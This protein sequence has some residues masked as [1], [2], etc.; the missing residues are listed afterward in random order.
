MWLY[1][2][3]FGPAAVYENI[4]T[5]DFQ[6]YTQCWYWIAFSSF[7]MQILR[8]FLKLKHVSGASQEINSK[9]LTPILKQFKQGRDI[10]L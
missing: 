7:C 4:C 5:Q 8:C 3:V 9:A 10:P 6:R 2:L 1:L